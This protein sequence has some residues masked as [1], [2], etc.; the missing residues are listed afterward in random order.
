MFF[1]GTFL[2][3]KE[4]DDSNFIKKLK[5]NN[6]LIYFYENGFIYFRRKEI[7]NLYFICF[8]GLKDKYYSKQSEVR[9]IINS[10]NNKFIKYMKDNNTIDIGNILAKKH[11]K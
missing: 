4:N 11:I 5:E 10:K 8:Y 3:T 6:K 7:E 9:I 2:S 1:G